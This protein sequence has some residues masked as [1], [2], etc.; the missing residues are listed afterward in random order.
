MKDTVFFAV[1]AIAVVTFLLVRNA[2]KKQKQQ[3][4]DLKNQ[5]WQQV[6]E[7]MALRREVEFLNV[8]S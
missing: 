2:L 8:P 5:I 1:L 7:N 3:T 4:E 6:G